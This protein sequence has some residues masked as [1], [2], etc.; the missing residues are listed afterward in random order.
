MSGGN[1]VRG[2]RYPISLPSERAAQRRTFDERLFIRFRGLFHL[3]A[4]RLMQLPPRSRLCRLLLIRLVVRAY[5]AGNRRDF[6]VLLM[7]LDPEIE[8]H[9]STNLMAPDM[10]TVFYGR[11]GYVQVWRY[12][13]DAFE[14]IGFEPEGLLDLGDRL[15]VP[16][17][18][19][20]PDPPAA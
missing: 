10:E 11:D 8:Y 12:W 4:G 17:Q 20:G 9:P 3:L 7:G 1:V 15:F 5:A 18:L 14:D 16:A 2:V 6:E 13:L 19:R